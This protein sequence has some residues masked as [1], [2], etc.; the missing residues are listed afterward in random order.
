MV[1][2]APIGTAKDLSDRLDVLDGAGEVELSMLASGT[3]TADI[4]VAN[5]SKVPA[6]VAMSGDATIATTGA[7]TIA[8]NAISNAKM[9]DNAVGNA[10]LADNAVGQAEV[11]DDAI[12]VAEL[13]YVTRDITVAAEA[14]TGTATNAADAG[15][16]IMGFYPSN[17]ESAVKTIALNGS[18]GQLDVTMNAAQ[19]AG[20]AAHVYVTI[21]QA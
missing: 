16:A 18:T 13:K 5:G 7:V 21:L 14:S 4:I 11:I 12:G 8:N 1:I 20:Q 6:Y 15:G 17:A 9:A 3:N 19:S 10:E 2:K